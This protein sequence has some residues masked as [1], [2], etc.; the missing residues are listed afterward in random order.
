MKRVGSSLSADNTLS[1]LEKVG[2]VTTVSSLKGL[3]ED[4]RSAEVA[5]RRAGDGL[6]IL[7]IKGKRSSLSRRLLAPSVTPDFAALPDFALGI[8]DH[9]SKE[10]SIISSLIFYSEK[11]KPYI[12]PGVAPLFYWHLPV[13]FVER[14]IFHELIIVSIY[15]PLHLIKKL[16]SRGFDVQQERDKLKI[17]RRVGRHIARLE[18]TE[19]FV[20]LITHYFFD[21]DSIADL[22]AKASHTLPDPPPEEGIRVDLRFR[23]F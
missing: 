21:E 10:N 3:Y 5:Y 13:D 8:M 20:F 12:L 22:I 18:H 4:L 23:F 14:I 2:V 16:R 1:G 9:E 11:G 7:A 17:S 19:Y 15:N 6:V